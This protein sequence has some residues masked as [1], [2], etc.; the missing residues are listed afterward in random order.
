ME[1]AQMLTTIGLFAAFIAALV[2]NV[3]TQIGLSGRALFVASMLL[4]ILLGCLFAAGGLLE[5]RVLRR[6]PDLL[7]GGVLGAL[8]GFGASGGTD[9]AKNLSASGAEA[10]AR[11][12]AQ[13]RESGP[14]APAAPVDDG[15]DEVDLATYSR[16]DWPQTQAAE[17]PNWRP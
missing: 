14:R 17:D 1:T 6:F 13:Y 7:S 12:D 2:Q 5:F 11:F 15:W 4:G 8:S 16:T 9:W 3:K 10:R